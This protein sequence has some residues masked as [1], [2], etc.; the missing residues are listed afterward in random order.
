MKNRSSS[1]FYY[2]PVTKTELARAYGVNIKTFDRWLKPLNKSLG[3]RL[4]RL[5]TPLQ[6]Q[7]IFRHFGKPN[8]SVL[9]SEKS[10]KSRRR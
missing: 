8:L 1:G 5:Y 6:L 7:I 4:G 9:Y 2:E 10:K 3:K